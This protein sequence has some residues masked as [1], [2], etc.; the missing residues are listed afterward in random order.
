MFSHLKTN[1]LHGYHLDKSMA[2]THLD[3]MLAQ[4]LHTFLSAQA[5]VNDTQPCCLRPSDGLSGAV[6]R[7]S[8]LHVFR[9]SVPVAS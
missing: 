2:S 5:L 3:T 4:I 6:N 1:L 7:Q 8:I 9:R